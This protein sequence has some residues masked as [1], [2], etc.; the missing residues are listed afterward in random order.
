M[1]SA[2][3]MEELQVKLKTWKTE[4]MK[5]YLRVNMRKTKIMVAGM[6][7]DLLNKS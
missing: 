4:I 5:K 1:I 6:D 3:S 2:V 7:L